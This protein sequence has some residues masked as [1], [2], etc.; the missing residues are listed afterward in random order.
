MPGAT[1]GAGDIGADW[2]GGSEQDDG[3]GDEREPFYF[4]R[5]SFS[6]MYFLFGL[7]PVTPSKNPLMVLISA[8]MFSVG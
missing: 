1:V 2:F 8:S 4:M 7:M 3:Q 6:V 5:Q